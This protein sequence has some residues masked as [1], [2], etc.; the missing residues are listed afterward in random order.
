MEI[1]HVRVDAVGPEIPR[2]AWAADMPEQYMTN[3]IVRVTTRGGLEGI[4]GAIVFTDFGYTTAIDVIRTDAEGY[5]HAPEGPGLGARM[6]WEAIDAA[7]FLTYE[8]TG[9]D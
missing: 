6:D 2:F 3:N 5:V 8:V 9:R 7:S 1:D 4:A